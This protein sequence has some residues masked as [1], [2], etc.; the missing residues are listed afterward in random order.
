MVRKPTRASTASSNESP[1]KYKVLITGAAKRI[2]RA[3]AEAFADAGSDV[4]I[5]YHTSHDEAVELQR[6]LQKKGV[7]AVLCQA[8]LRAPDA[9][10]EIL[11]QLSRLDFCP[12]LLV[13]SASIYQRIPL[14]DLEP[15]ALAELYRINFFAPF[16]LMRLFAKQAPQNSCI[17]NL[18]DQRIAFPDP[19]A[20]GYAFAKQSLRDA[21]LACALEWAP[22]IRVNAVAPGLVLSP[23][24]VPPEKLAPLLPKVP[25]QTRTTEQDIANACLFLANAPAVTGQILFV[26]GGLHLRGHSPETPLR[27]T[28]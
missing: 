17:I 28:K 26:D 20:G 22:R 23:P 25:M 27:R 12:N 15:E 24:G 18:L 3:I 10:K 2:G 11:A 5:H 16:D 14:S 4:A 1:M 6:A 19:D 9:P 8:D 7:L 13:N 21:T